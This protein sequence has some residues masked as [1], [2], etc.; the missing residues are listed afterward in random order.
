MQE[1]YAIGRIR[2]A[3]DILFW[4]WKAAATPPPQ[5]HQAEQWHRNRTTVTASHHSRYKKYSSSWLA[6]ITIKQ[7]APA[8]QDSRHF[9]PRRRSVRELR[10]RD[11]FELTGDCYT[12]SQATLQ[13]KTDW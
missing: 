7:M 3:C 9:Q 8:D 12:R 4:G 11:R 5:K 1:T 6:T 2:I 13:W 10:R